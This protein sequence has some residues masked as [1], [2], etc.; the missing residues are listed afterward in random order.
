MPFA[1]TLIATARAVILDKK[2]TALIEAAVASYRLR[3]GPI[4]FRFTRVPLRKAEDGSHKV[5]AYHA[6]EVFNI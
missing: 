5:Y 3:R 1:A 6:S 4:V 2:V